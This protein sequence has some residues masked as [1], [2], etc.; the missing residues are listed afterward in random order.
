MKLKLTFLFILS[1]FLLIQCKKEKE[2]MPCNV[3]GG[4]GSVVS[5]DTCNLHPILCGKR[6]DEVSFL[7]THNAHANQDDFSALA[8]NQDG[9][10]TAQLEAGIRGIGVKVYNTSGSPTGWLFC[11][12]AP[13]DLY[14][15]HGD[16]TL[17][18]ETFQNQL[19]QIKTFYEANPKEV[20]PI[21][22]EGDAP[23][24]EIMA[25]FAAE[26]MDVYMH[27]QDFSQ[28]WPL[29]QEMIDNNKRLVVFMD[30]NS[31][32]DPFPKIHDMW[33]FIYDT[34][35]DHSSSSTFDCNKFRGNDSTG[36]L[37]TLNHFITNVTPQQ[38]D[39]T[40]INDV[41]FLLPRTRSCWAYNSH[42]PNFVMID[43]WNTSNP[44]QSVDSLNLVGL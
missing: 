35:Y 9:D 32:T 38:G 13:D 4:G 30:D 5:S 27:E 31:A 25:A 23:P 14:V 3:A 15:Y 42:I 44:L 16:P 11:S 28:P 36:Q 7:M 1:V 43:F 26:G 12:G 33:N 22:I 8:A 24:N 34:D 40:I 37:F 2:T 17:G 21:T 39:A 6:F 10:I 29:L 19:Q 20:I 41:S 18:C